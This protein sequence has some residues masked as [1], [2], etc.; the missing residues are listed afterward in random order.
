MEVVEF[1]PFEL[2]FIS[3]L[4]FYAIF[5]LIFSLKD[6]KRKERGKG[7]KKMDYSSLME[8]VD[9]EDVSFGQLRKI[10]PPD[11]FIILKKHE[12]TLEEKRNCEINNQYNNYI[13]SEISNFSLGLIVS[14]K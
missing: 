2:L 7:E 13:I 10:I 4:F 3:A 12:E 6:R 11:I 8:D 14:L 9:F 5:L 1:S